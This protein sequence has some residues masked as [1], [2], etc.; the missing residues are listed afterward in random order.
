MQ[1]DD[2]IYMWLNREAVGFRLAFETTNDLTF[3][4]WT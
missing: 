1:F 3:W 4:E 2:I